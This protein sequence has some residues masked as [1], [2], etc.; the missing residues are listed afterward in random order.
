[1]M[2][3]AVQRVQVQDV[4][5]SSWYIVPLGLGATIGDLLREVQRRV[6]SGQ[7]VEH[8][9]LANTE[10]ARLNPQDWASSVLS[11]GEKILAV[12]S[13]MEQSQAL[14]VPS[15]A[16]NTRKMWQ[17]PHAVPNAQHELLAPVRRL[18]SWGFG[19]AAPSWESSYVDDYNRVPTTPPFSIAPVQTS[20]HRQG[21]SNDMRSRKFSRQSSEIHPQVF[22]TEVP[23]FNLE[24]QCSPHEVREVGN[25]L[26]ELHSYAIQQFDGGQSSV[27]PSVDMSDRSPR[28]WPRSVY[29][30]HKAQM[31]WIY[32]DNKL[33][34]CVNDAGA[35]RSWYWKN[36]AH[37]LMEHTCNN[38]NFML[39]DFPTNQEQFR[40]LLQLDECSFG[41]MATCGE[42]TA[43]G[44]ATNAKSRKQV[45]KLALAITGGFMNS[46]S[47]G[48][49]PCE[50]E[51]LVHQAREL[52]REAGKFQ[53]LK[54]QPVTAS[55]YQ[56]VN[57]GQIDEVVGASQEC[58]EGTSMDTV[59]NEVLR[60]DDQPA[61]Q[62][63]VIPEES[64]TSNKHS[65]PACFSRV[66][67]RVTGKTSSGGC[68][69][70][71]SD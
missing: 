3:A 48:I 16:S 47:D 46:W 1:M 10:R 45:A 52:H 40:A 33:V 39:G 35:S 62:E 37:W 15:V 61:S 2:N 44:V 38:N 63:G 60:T 5:T 59:S 55:I 24:A 4:D 28:K 7:R 57:S 8:L 58:T 67:R 41:Q 54:A 53:S 34:L 26:L 43:I 50:L 56:E 49:E 69:S 70:F 14:P 68:N 20:Q 9:S 42:H 12:S 17:A 11:N 21:W 51:S 29:D 64:A 13:R 25:P 31:C 71:C 23:P 19:Q 27:H 30:A 6:P 36:N 22:A 32:H 65:Q 66:R 18:A